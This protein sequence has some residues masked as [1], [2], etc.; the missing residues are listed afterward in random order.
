[1]VEVEGRLCRGGA[2]QMTT[3]GTRLFFVFRPG[4]FWVGAH[5]SP[6]N[7]RLCV[8]LLPCF[9][10]AAVLPGGVAPR[11]RRLL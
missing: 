5:W 7:R 11:G 9:T 8:N 2:P 10:L 1:M 3:E 4:S 6:T